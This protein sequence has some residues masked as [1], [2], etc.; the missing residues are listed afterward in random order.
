MNRIWVDCLLIIV[1]VQSSIGQDTSS[2]NT[3]TF[4]YLK[5]KEGQKESLRVFLHESWF[6]MDSIAVA[7]RLF[8]EYKLMKNAQATQYPTEWDFIVA[9]EYYTESTY[10]DI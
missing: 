7:R 10:T 8:N 4:T 1:S 5:T 6:V 2:Q 9:V 3:W